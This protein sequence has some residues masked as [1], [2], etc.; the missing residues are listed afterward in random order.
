V[1][2]VGTMIVSVVAFLIMFLIIQRFGFKPL[3]RMLEQRRIHI[4]T[5]INEAEQGRAQAERLLA[6]QR[7]LLEQA[8]N[9]AKQLLDAARSRAD[10][11]AR[12]L[13]QEAQ[14]ESAR[15][16]AEGR[17]LIERERAEALNEVYTKVAALTV[18]LTTK[19]LRNHVSQ[20][21]HDE[22][23]A[24]AEKRLGELVC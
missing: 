1:I 4:E 9:E 23:V 12:E 15:I 22:M 17:Q 20:S 24:E 16:L 11:Q 8:R 6:E 18:E 5:E 19:L 13:V 10:E 2:Q 3:G 14:T 21:V 7:Q